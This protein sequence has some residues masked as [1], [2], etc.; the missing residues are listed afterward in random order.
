LDP[1]ILRR[2]ALAWT[3][4]WQLI[5]ALLLFLPAGSLRFWEA[6]VYWILFFLLTLLGTFYFL[7]HD[8]ALLESRLQFGPAGEPEKSQRIIQ[9]LAITLGCVMWVVPGIERRHHGSVIPGPLVLVADAVLV[10]GILITFL[11]ARENSYASRVVEVKPGQRVVSTGPYSIV[12]HPMYA[13]SL[14]LFLATPPAL[15]SLW[16][17]VLVLPLSA[18]IVARLLDEER[19]LSKNLPGYK[20]YCEKV[21]Y[22]LIPYVW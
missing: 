17:L 18:V 19:Y 12:R 10:V 16:A 22:R 5:L 15:G 8:P 20:E 7:K 21:R 2:R 1:K 14:L 13:G 3:V 6:W 9:V 4:G 11:A